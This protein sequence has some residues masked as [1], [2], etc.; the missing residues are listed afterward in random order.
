MLL[1]GELH[2]CHYGTLLPAGVKERL[3]SF[4][5]VFFEN[6]LYR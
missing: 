4:G 3:G 6:I 1:G 2:N 5:K